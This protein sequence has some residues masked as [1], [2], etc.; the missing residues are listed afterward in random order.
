[1]KASD[2]RERTDVELQD[3][4]GDTSRELF[5]LKIKKMSGDTSLPFVKMRDLRRNLARIKTVQTERK[6]KIP[7]N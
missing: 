5:D 2:L 6:N 1:M 7:E 3:L 4:F